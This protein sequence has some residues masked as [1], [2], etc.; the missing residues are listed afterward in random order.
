[1]RDDLID[2]HD[3]GIFVMQVEEI[4][5]VAQHGAIISAFFHQHGMKAVGISIDS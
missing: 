2:M 4:N 5:L 3:I 1:M